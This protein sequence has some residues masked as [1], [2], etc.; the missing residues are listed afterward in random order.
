MVA[1]EASGD[2]L[3]ASLMQALAQRYPNAVIEGV[4]GPRMIQAGLHNL[5]DM[6]RLSVMGIVE[7]LRRLPD[8]F[9]LRRDLYR[10][11][12]THRPDLFIGIDAP[13]FNIG[14]EQQLREA[15]IPTVHYV[16]PSVWAWRG[17]RIHRIAKAVNLMLTLFPFEEKYYQAKNIP[18]CCVGHPLAEQIPL[19]PDVLA[20]R[21]ALGL[22][23]QQ[24]YVALLPGSRDQEIKYLAE[25]LLLAAKKISSIKPDVVFLTAAVSEVHCAALHAA[26]QAIVPELPLRFFIKQGHEVMAASDILVVKS[27]TGTLEGMLFKKPM[28][29]VYR[30]SAL[31]YWLAKRLV[32]TPHI[33]LP[34]LIA[35]ERIVPELIQAE[36]TPDIIAEHVLQYLQHPEKIEA[37]RAR[38][39]SL[40]Q[41]LKMD[42]AN[43]AVEAM[44]VLLQ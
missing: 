9:R 8:L 40:H 17:Y 33:G 39:E 19:Q 7:P 3:G 32:R 44:T 34:N 5:F 27:G 28:V 16:S 11:F 21:R 25:P 24:T 43:Q 22:D 41:R 23:E 13:D 29:I 1:G 35:G 37:L 26:H 31:T 20:A 14:L 42:S 10:H 30:M 15:H 4:G 38:F 6:E 18:V 12:T 36:V 2:L